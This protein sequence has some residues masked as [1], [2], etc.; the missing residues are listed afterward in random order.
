MRSL[1][2]F[3]KEHIRGAYKKIVDQSDPISLG[4]GDQY[5]VGWQTQR[6]GQKACS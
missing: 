6:Q 1:N 4:T 5:F 2:R 3:Y